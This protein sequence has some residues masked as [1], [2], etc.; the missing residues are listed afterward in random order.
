MQTR[1]AVLRTTKSLCFQWAVY[2]GR[3]ASCHSPR[4]LRVPLWVM[5][6]AAASFFSS[7]TE[8]IRKTRL[9]TETWQPDLV[10]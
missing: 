7:T 1:V 8:V 10:G 9:F 4:K 3:I 5:Q 2:S 6:L